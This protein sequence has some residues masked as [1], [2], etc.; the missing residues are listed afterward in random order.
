MN[1]LLKIKN[2][3]KYSELVYPVNNEGGAPIVH[4]NGADNRQEQGQAGRKQAQHLVGEAHGLSCGQRRIPQLKDA[5]AG[6]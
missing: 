1:K 3:I 6:S 2:A 4:P 5:V